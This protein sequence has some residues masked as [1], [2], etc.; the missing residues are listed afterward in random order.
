MGLAAVVANVLLLAPRNDTAM[1]LTAMLGR[2]LTAGLHRKQSSRCHR[3][4]QGGRSAWQL[5]AYPPTREDRV[6]ALL[7]RQRSS[8]DRPDQCRLAYVR[9]QRHRS[10][11]Q[12]GGFLAER[13]VKF[14][15]ARRLGDCKI[16]GHVD[17]HWRTYT[18]V[19]SPVCG[20]SDLVRGIAP[21]P[22]CMAHGERWR[23]TARRWSPGVLLIGGT[24]S[25]C[26]NGPA[27]VLT[28][29]SFSMVSGGGRACDRAFDHRLSVLASTAGVI[30]DGAIGDGADGAREL[31]VVPAR[32]RCSFFPTAIRYRPEARKRTKTAVPEGHCRA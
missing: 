28:A 15:P 25:G 10:I 30:R 29:R 23:T 21:S 16:Y 3:C 14:W 24:V 2:G 7:R 1:V 18:P 22:P 9:T 32:A 5:A 20:S 19:P 12:A 31:L 13:E 4:T 17:S 11:P 8:A 6:V 26:R 27:P